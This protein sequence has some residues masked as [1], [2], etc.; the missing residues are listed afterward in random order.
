MAMYQI[1]LF[2]DVILGVIAQLLLKQGM[3][4]AGLSRIRD[5]SFF[6]L[7]KKMFLN[8]PVILGFLAYGVSLLL[9]L[10]V[11]SGLELSYAYP[12]ISSGYFF[13]ALF[14]IVLFN[15]KVS[16]KRWASIGIIIFGVI[17][18]GIS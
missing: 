18:V 2:I 4:K 15:E 17:L 9:W 11:I 3:R 7:C 12:M 8:G 10:V 5:I 1:L 6:A 13:V 14:S 16:W